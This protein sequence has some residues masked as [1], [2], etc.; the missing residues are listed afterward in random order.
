MPM[1]RGGTAAEKL[2]V[3]LASSPHGH[4]ALTHA[5]PCESGLAHVMHPKY[6]RIDAENIYRYIQ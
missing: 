5:H 4:T 2:L 3:R 6:T 1:H